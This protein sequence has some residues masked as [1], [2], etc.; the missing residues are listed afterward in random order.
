MDLLK[1]MKARRAYTRDLLSEMIADGL[2]E[3]D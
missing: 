3:H 2:F 1:H